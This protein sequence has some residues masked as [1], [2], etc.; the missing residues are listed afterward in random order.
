MGMLAGAISFLPGGL[1][2]AEAAMVALLLTN[3]VVLGTA[4]LATVICRAVTLWFAVLLG[5]VA[6]LIL[7]QRD[8]L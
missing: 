2:G 7:E 1:G 6:M 8:N 5:I 3:G 4:V